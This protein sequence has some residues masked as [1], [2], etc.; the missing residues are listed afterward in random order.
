MLPS[1]HL[2]YI[3]SELKEKSFLVWYSLSVLSVLR[4]MCKILSGG[5]KGQATS[6]SVSWSS[7]PNQILRSGVPL[8]PGLWTDG[9]A[10]PLLEQPA[11][12]DMFLTMLCVETWNQL[13]FSV[14]FLFLSCYTVFYRNTGFP[15]KSIF[16]L[17]YV[18]THSLP[19][20]A[21]RT[22]TVC[23][24]DAYSHLASNVA[25]LNVYCFTKWNC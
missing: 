13:W 12:P 7:Q 19:L 5:E 17:H 10:H 9:A 8:I 4:T 14:L 11:Y 3:A 1:Y 21:L 2:S 15:S 23:T 20:R 22:S 18:L 16:P 24:T 25:P 6:I